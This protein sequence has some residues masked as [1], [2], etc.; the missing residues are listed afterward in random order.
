MLANTDGYWT[1]ASDYNIYLDGQGRVHVLPHDMNE[2]F[3]EEGGGPD[4]T[5]GNAYFYE[6]KSFN[7]FAASTGTLKISSLG[8]MNFFL[9]D[10]ETVLIVGAGETSILN[11]SSNT[12][13]GD[14][15]IQRRQ[16]T[17]DSAEGVVQSVEFRPL[18]NGVTPLSNFYLPK[19]ARIRLGYSTDGS[20]GVQPLSLKRVAL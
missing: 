1:R 19:P 15:L 3:E 17:E 9:P 13:G 14:V 7:D 18:L 5:M 2:G 12:L 20:G 11:A 16:R 10:C 6:I 4:E 8:D